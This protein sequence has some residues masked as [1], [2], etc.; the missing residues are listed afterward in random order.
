M[1]DIFFQE[2]FMAKVFEIFSEKIKPSRSFMI[3]PLHH[4]AVLSALAIKVKP[5]S[6]SSMLYHNCSL[7]T[8][9]K[10]HQR[11]FYKKIKKVIRRSFV[12]HAI[13]CNSTD[14]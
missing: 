10:G 9:N 14:V 7:S 5:L 1:D 12:G 4:L 6:H 3:S 11:P 13:S 2:Y 8:R